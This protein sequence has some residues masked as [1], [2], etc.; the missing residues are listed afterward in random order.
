MS[1][2]QLFY[3]ISYNQYTSRFEGG[4]TPVEQAQLLFG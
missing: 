3:A 4:I 1:F 2:G